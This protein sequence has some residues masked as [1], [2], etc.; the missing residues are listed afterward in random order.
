MPNNGR[1]RPAGIPNKMTREI[2]EM[3]MQALE[4]AG[5]VDYLTQ[6][7]RD[8]PGPFLTLLGK[9]LPLQVTGAGGGPLKVEFPGLAELFDKV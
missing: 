5:G 4:N 1:G 8:N 3:V 2:K 7:A 9:V 6:Q